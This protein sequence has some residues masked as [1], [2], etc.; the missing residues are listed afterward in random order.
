[1]TYVRPALL[2]L[3]CAS[4]IES[5]YPVSDVPF[6]AEDASFRD[7]PA[8]PLDRPE[9]SEHPT[10]DDSPTTPDETASRDAATRRVDAG[11]ATVA[12][13]TPTCFTYPDNPDYRGCGHCTRV[14]T[15]VVYACSPP[16]FAACYRYAVDCIDPGFLHC[17]RDS[18][19]RFPGLEAACLALCDRIN[20]RDAG[21]RC[22]LRP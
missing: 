7:V 21:D 17:A 3:G 19:D 5:T 9:K 4:C 20:L 13:A 2:L 14:D 18:Y 12:D 6:L 11:D 8:A 1:M 15:Q 10:P 16:P 22:G